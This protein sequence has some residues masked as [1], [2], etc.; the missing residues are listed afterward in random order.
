MSAQADN[1]ISS[2]YRLSAT[3]MTSTWLLT[4]DIESAYGLWPDLDFTK[5]EVWQTS[6]QTLILV[7]WG[8]FLGL[9]TWA[10]MHTSWFFS[11][12]TI[13]ISCLTVITPQGC[14]VAKRHT[15]HS[16]TKATKSTHNNQK[17]QITTKPNSE[18]WD[19]KYEYKLRVNL[20]CLR[21]SLKSVVIYTVLKHLGL[22][23]FPCLCVSKKKANNVVMS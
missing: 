10:T 1:V 8:T 6:L 4:K 9:L 5:L 21:F 2:F 16:L 14:I 3:N 20:S 7:P 19:L 23:R 18:L 13:I 11:N 15:A 12:S 17:Y 22:M